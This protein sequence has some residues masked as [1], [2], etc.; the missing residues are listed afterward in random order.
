MR[1]PMFR[2]P[3]E[4]PVLREGVRMNGHT[5]PLLGRKKP[6]LET[7]RLA[8]VEAKPSQREQME[9]GRQMLM[10]CAFSICFSV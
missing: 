3:K 5:L 1:F 7:D 8:R 6:A 10:Q 2:A 9:P 4:W